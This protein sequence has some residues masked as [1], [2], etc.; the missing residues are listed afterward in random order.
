MRAGFYFTLL[1]IPA[2]LVSCKPKKTENLE[3]MARRSSHPEAVLVKTVK[4]EPSTFYHELI[5]NGKAWSARKAVVPSK[6]NGI[7]EA[8][9]M[10]SGQKVRA[11]DLLAVSEEFEYKTQLALA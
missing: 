10:Q 8:S 3:E 9:H 6:V 7:I 4:L 5:S 11:G 1:I 2:F